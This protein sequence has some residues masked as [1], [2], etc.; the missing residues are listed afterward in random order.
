[1]QPVKDVQKDANHTA[2]FHTAAGTPEAHTETMK[3]AAGIAVTAAL[4][5]ADESFASVVT[6]DWKRGKLASEEVGGMY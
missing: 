5:A 1:M 3:S 6:E 4:F 2:A